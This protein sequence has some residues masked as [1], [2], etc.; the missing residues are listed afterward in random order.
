MAYL[1]WNGPTGRGEHELSGETSIGRSAANDLRLPV[2]WVSK[3]HAVV[4]EA[5]GGWVFEDAGSRNG[6]LVNDEAQ[7]RCTLSNGDLIRIGP[8]ELRFCLALPDEQPAAPK[9]DDPEAVDVTIAGLASA[10]RDVARVATFDSLSSTAMPDTRPGQDAGAL[11][12]R[13]KAAYVISQ[14][15]ATTLDSALILDRVLSALF[16]IFDRAERAFILLVDPQS[17]EVKTG[18]VRRRDHVDEEEISVSKTA[19]N[20][21]LRKREALLCLDAMN[22]ADLGGADSVAALG[23]RSLMIAPLVSREELHGAIYVDTVSTAVV[24]TEDDLQLLSAAASQVAGS[25]S[26]ADL[27]GR[28]VETERLAA[29]G[30]TVAGLSHCIKNILQGIK[31]GAY[32]LEHGLTGSDLARVTQGWEMMKT[33][34]DFMEELVLD[35]LS[36][37]KP[38]LPEYEVADLNALCAEICDI[39]RGR[40]TEGKVTVAFNPDDG[41]APLEIDPKGIRRS[42]LNLVTNAVDACADGGGEVTVET[43]RPDEDGVARVLIRDSGCGM[44]PE[45]LGKLFAVFFSTKGSKGTGLGLPITKKIIEEHGGRLDVTS[46]EGAGTTF[47][48]SLPLERPAPGTEGAPDD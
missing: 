46:E 19:L 12:R 21:A 1:I 43:R 4:R 11:R 5:E 42:L 8:Y 36:Y 9:R 14:A 35:L 25:L 2:S 33:K 41:L 15:T 26:N 45:T 20:S 38:R 13:L 28:L 16:E 23:I 34:T 32:I 17:H 27:H 30:Q 44:S 18:A 40:E 24:F 29:V 7:N 10:D 39:G 3:R 22:D 6:S 37:S 47:A 31:G 48:V